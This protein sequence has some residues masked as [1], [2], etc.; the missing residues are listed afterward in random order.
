MAKD[1]YIVDAN[2]SEATT[3]WPEPS[4][5]SDFAG[6]AARVSNRVIEGMTEVKPGLYVADKSTSIFSRNEH[7]AGAEH[8]AQV[9]TR[10]AN[11]I[12]DKYLKGQREHGGNIRVKAGMLGH[13]EDESRDLVVYLD[14]LREQLTA[15]RNQALALAA[16]VDK[17]IG[18]PEP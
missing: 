11:A 14:V 18:V 17:I 13:A 15:V 9:A 6:L 4:A 5:P 2:R 1:V 7:M 10:A 16:S 3:T 8:A 12:E